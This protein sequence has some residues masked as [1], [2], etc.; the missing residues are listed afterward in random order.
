[1]ALER[2]DQLSRGLGKTLLVWSIM[3][4]LLGLFL[5]LS[6]S[7]LIQGIAVQAILW[8][9]IDAVIASFA[10]FKQ[11][12]QTVEKMVKILGIN[13][14]LDIF[15]QVLGLFLLIFMWQDAFA[16]GNGIGVVI[17]GA[18]LFVL[19]LY[20]FYQFKKMKPR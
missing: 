9:I 8:G 19:D 11:N 3:S 5:Y 6:N 1:M 12:D 2:K 17:Q 4:I 16:A 18:F 20:Y 7:S 15:Y 14:G 13:V 10:L